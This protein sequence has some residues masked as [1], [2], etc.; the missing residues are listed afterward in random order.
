MPARLNRGLIQTVLGPIPPSELG[1]TTTHEHLY[2]DFS[3]MYRPARDVP[4]EELTDAPI[5]LENLGWIRR[6]YYSNRF[7]LTLMDPE[8][9]VRELELYRDAG[10]GGIVETTT[11]GIGRNPEALARI[12]RES[13]VH[14]VMGAGFYVDAVLPDDWMSGAL[15]TLPGRSSPTSRTVSA[16]AASRPASSARWAARGR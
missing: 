5:T 8:T 13:G 16:K 11:I 9:T 1:P 15:R 2:I 10:G 4:S 7:N 3:F 12:S 14:V 6:N